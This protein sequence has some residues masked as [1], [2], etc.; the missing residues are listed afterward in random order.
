MQLTRYS[1]NG[2][3][4]N[5]SFNDL[6]KTFQDAVTTCI[7]LDIRYIWID[8]LC[9]LQDSP[10]DWAIQGSKMTQVCTCP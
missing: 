1:I 2:F 5:V 7:A 6:P 10:E 8:S 4:Q 9:I 3:K